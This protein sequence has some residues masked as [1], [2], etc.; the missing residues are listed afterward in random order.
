MGTTRCCVSALDTLEPKSILTIRLRDTVKV[1]L[2]ATMWVTSRFCFWSAINNL[3]SWRTVSVVF[4][5]HDRVNRSVPREWGR[6]NDGDESR[7]R[8]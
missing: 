1:R 4:S 7:R 5:D 3:T 2:A 8:Q 6:R